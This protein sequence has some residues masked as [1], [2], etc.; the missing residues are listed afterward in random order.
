MGWLDCGRDAVILGHDAVLQAVVK[1]GAAV[2]GDGRSAGGVDGCDEVYSRFFHHP[3]SSKD[4]VT[5]RK[6]FSGERVSISIFLAGL[7]IK[8]P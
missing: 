7:V 1:F 3:D 8:I 4:V 2:D 6:T 5:G